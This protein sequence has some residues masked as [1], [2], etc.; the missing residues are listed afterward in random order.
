M[1][2]S[3]YAADVRGMVTRFVREGVLARQS[4][5]ISIHVDSSNARGLILADRPGLIYQDGAFLRVDEAFHVDGDGKLQRSH[6]AYHYERPGGYYLRFER[7]QHDG[8]QLYKPEYHVH[9]CWRLP[10]IP[11]LPITL[12]ETLEFVHVNFYNAVHRQRLVGQTL[13]IQI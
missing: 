6:Y 8:D 4:R 7:E 12:A 13:N 2:A 9:V 11:A 10:H 5:P 3:N 1:R